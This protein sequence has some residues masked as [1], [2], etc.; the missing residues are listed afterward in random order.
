MSLKL[1]DLIHFTPVEPSKEKINFVKLIT[2]DLYRNEEGPEARKKLA[3]AVH[4][5][6]TTQGFFTLIN[7]GISEETIQR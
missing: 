7:H 5:A 2:I 4:E 3:E 6:M 1:S